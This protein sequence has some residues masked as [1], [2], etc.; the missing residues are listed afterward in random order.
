M[1]GVEVQ[2]PFSGDASRALSLVA[3][4]LEDLGYEM[5]KHEDGSL[6]M[7]F[8]GK[9][10]TS[11]PAKMKHRVV[12]KPRADQLTFAFGTGLIASHWSDEDRAWAQD[13]ANEVVAAV[14]AKL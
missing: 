14:R 3:R 1:N 11:D 9:W 13:R 4:E 6:E 5:K 12:V 8:E 7:S 2:V 10:F